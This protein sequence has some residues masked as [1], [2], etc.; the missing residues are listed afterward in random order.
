MSDPVLTET[1]RPGIRQVTLNRPDRLNAMNFCTVM[2][3]CGRLAAAP[4]GG[5]APSVR[6]RPE[7]NPRPAPVRT[8]T[9]Q[10]GSAAASSSASYSPATNA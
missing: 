3:A 9:R 10:V 1:V 4:P 5:L 8:I 2:P 6:S 7:Q